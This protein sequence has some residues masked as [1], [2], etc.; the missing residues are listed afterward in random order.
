MHDIWK[1]NISQ[2][3]SILANRGLDPGSVYQ[4]TVSAVLSNYNMRSMVTTLANLNS[5]SLD[6]AYSFYKDR[7]ADASGFTFTF[8]G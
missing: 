3:R 6:K 7:F 2:T 8:V 1:G 5:A 4:D